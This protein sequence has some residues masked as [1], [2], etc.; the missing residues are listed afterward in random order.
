MVSNSWNRSKVSSVAWKNEYSA[1]A[2]SLTCE[3]SGGKKKNGIP[4]FSRAD[5]EGIGNGY[6]FGWLGWP[7]RKG[8]PE[9]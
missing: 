7:C 6:S 9:Q 1:R 5:V 8:G 4:F 3:S 2:G